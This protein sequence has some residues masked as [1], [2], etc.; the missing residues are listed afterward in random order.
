MRLSAANATKE[1]RNA[2]ARELTEMKAGSD[3]R[4]PVTRN[5]SLLLACGVFI[6]KINGGSLG[7]TAERK[8]VRPPANEKGY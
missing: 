6:G 7:E 5:V 4:L 3:G 8:R 1:N 2:V